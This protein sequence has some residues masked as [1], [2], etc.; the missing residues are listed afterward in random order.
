ML[1][2]ADHR[3]FDFFER[4][5]IN[6]NA[7][8]RDRI[9]PA[10]AV[11]REFDILT[12]FDE[13]DFA[14]DYVQLM[15]QSGVAEQVAVFAVHG[16][17]VF[18]FNQLQNELLLFLAGMAGNVDDAGGIV[19]VHERATPEHVIQHAENGLFV[20]GYDARGKNDC[21][22]LIDTNKSM[23]VHGDAR[24]GR[25]RLGLRAGSQD[26]DFARIE[27]SNILRTHNHAIGNAQVF[28]VV[29]DFDVIHHAAADKG[30]FAAD[31]RSNVNDLLNAMDG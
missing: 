7:A 13:Q 17:E 16:N 11:L 31:A 18:R 8:C 28:Q 21:V 14:A 19:V 6:Q 9:A 1:A 24:K 29:R 4:S 12:V 22:V 23:I 5:G 10:H 3:F 30:H 25:H 20:S 27:R 15:R 26:D 2:L